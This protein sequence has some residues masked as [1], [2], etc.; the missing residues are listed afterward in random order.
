MKVYELIKELKKYNSNNN[1]F[2]NVLDDSKGQDDIYP[3]E[4]ININCDADYNDTFILI[5]KH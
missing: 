2:V 3:I 1:V 4:D 5:T